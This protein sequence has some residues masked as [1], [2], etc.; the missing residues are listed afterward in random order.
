MSDYIVMREELATS[1]M[2]SAKRRY[3]EARRIYQRLVNEHGYGGSEE[4]VRRYVRLSK[5]RIGIGCICTQKPGAMH[6]ARRLS[7]GSE[8]A[9]PESA[10]N[11]TET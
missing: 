4:A 10:A 3:R 5:A 2:G 6:C 7:G 9:H 11:G 8:R 1:A